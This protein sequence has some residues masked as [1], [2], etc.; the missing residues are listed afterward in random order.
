MRRCSLDP[1]QWKM[2]LAVSEGGIIT[3][4]YAVRVSGKEWSYPLAVNAITCA[5][6]L[7]G[8]LP[9]QWTIEHP[10]VYAGQ[11]RCASADDVKK[12]EKLAESVRSD[13]KLLGAPAKLVRPAR[14]KGNV[15]KRVHHRRIAKRLSPSELALFNADYG[16]AVLDVRDAIALELYAL[17]RVGRGGTRR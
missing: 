17:G 16:D 9:V 8:P 13:L 12:L 15:P 5:A 10:Q 1:G 2:G 14:W 11:G 7:D 6:K 4:A 3:A